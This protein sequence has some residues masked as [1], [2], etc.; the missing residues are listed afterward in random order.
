[1]LDD[2]QLFNA[3]RSFLDNP[4][5]HSVHGTINFQAPAV[6][7]AWNSLQHVRSSLF[8]SFV[9]QT[10]RPPPTRSGPPGPP[11]S[12]SVNGTRMRNLS[13]REPPDIDR[14]DVEDFVDNLDSMAS[15]AFSN[16][17]EEVSIRFTISLWC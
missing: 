14:I 11:S 15:A 13:S 7:Q 3:I 6:Q 5:D 9:A 1:M 10:M 2:V 4:T 8:R 12:P 17:T 16:V